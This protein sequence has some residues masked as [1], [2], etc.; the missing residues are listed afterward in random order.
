MTLP[1]TTRLHQRIDELVEKIGQLSEVVA[2][3]LAACES[4]RP[5]VLGDLGRPSLT[6]RLGGIQQE[7]YD[8]RHELSGKIGD[9]ARDVTVLKTA[10]E[11]GARVFWTAI[12]VAG[13]LSGTVVGVLL[14]WWLGSG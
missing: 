4:C 1:D 3:S 6:D 8:V 10:R 5:L 9:L 2:E 7:I 11:I 12:G 14:K 13:T